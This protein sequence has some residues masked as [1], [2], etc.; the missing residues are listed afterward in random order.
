MTHLGALASAYLDGEVTIAESERVRRHLEECEACRAEMADLH[1]A[2]SALRTLPTLEV[3]VAVFAELGLYDD[4]VPLRRRA[5]TWVAAA[6]AAAAL[7]VGAA[8]LT[9][10]DP[11]DVHLEDVAQL[12]VSQSQ[13][14]PRLAPIGGFVV[15][16]GEAAE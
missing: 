3:P 15:E 14:S 16:G 11:V 7:F 9:A 8:T 2:R 1:A 10:P 6:A 13:L 4:V 12:H 5:V